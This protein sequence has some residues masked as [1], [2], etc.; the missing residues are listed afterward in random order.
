MYIGNHEDSGREGTAVRNIRKILEERQS[1]LGIRMKL[2][3]VGVVETNIAEELDF[4]PEDL[5]EHME[6]QAGMMAW[7]GALYRQKE[8]EL[9]A[10]EH[11][12]EMWYAEKYQ[13]RYEHLWTEAGRAKSAKPTVGAVEK[14]VKVRYG[15]RYSSWQKMLRSKRKE[16]NYLKD[17]GKWWEEKGR[18]LV[19]YARV[20]TA[21]MDMTGMRVKRDKKIGDLKEAMKTSKR[22]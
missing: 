3:K 17:T 19:V 6:C 12:Y 9:A 8:E 14:A 10:V 21:E 1:Q 15:K 22:R 2:P 11:R 4:E 18:M 20:M 5:N 13:E 7:W 16:V